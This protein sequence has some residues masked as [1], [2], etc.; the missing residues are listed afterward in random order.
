MKAI[1]TILLSTTLFSCATFIQTVSEEDKDAEGTLNGTYAVVQHKAALKQN[2]ERWVFT[3]SGLQEERSFTISA[4]NGKLNIFADGG[5]PID[6]YVDS[7]GKFR[8]EFPLDGVAKESALSEGSITKG[9]RTLIIRGRLSPQKTTSGLL[10]VGIEQFGNTG[11][12]SRLTIKK[13]GT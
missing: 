2:I 1:I 3:C 12:S 10:T 5:R 9:K 11:C 7:S 13:Q 6:T 8:A 4:L